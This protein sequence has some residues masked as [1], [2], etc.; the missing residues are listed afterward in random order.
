VQP[1]AQGI[2]FSDRRRPA[3]QNEECCLAGVFGLLLMM[4]HTKTHF[5]DQRSVPFHERGESRLIVLLD[6]AFQ[7]FTVRKMADL[8]QNSK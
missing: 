7:Q 2:Q 5:Q 8:M 6:K 4:E 3:D 1:T